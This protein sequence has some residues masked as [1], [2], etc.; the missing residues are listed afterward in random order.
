[1]NK[2]IFTT[3]NDITQYFHRQNSFKKKLKK[4]N[5]CSENVKTLTYDNLSER[6]R[7]QMKSKVLRL[8][9]H[10]I[11]RRTLEKKEN[12]IFCKIKSKSRKMLFS[13]QPIE[14]VSKNELMTVQQ[15]VKHKKIKFG[16]KSIKNISISTTPKPRDHSR[17]K[18]LSRFIIKLAATIR[19]EYA[20]NTAYCP[21]R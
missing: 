15:I 16:S 19:G 13:F 20:L 6:L 3:R 21:H 7:K 18:C 8:S 1:M 10:I 5:F 12:N 17:K 14:T 2:I 11:V 4:L 9:K